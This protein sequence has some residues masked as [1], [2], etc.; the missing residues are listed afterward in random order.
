MSP[1]PILPRQQDQAQA[2]LPSALGIGS[3][4][5]APSVSSVYIISTSVASFS[6]HHHFASASTSG[7]PSPTAP[8]IEQLYS[9]AI[10]QTQPLTAFPSN[11]LSP[12]LQSDVSHSDTIPWGWICGASVLFLVSTIMLISWF[13]FWS[14][15]MKELREAGGMDGPQARAIRRY[16][17]N[18][19]SDTSS[20]GYSDDDRNVREGATYAYADEYP[21]PY[22]VLSGQPNRRLWSF[23]FRNFRSLSDAEAEIEEGKV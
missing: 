16:R 18:S 8:S 19:F 15:T 10:N 2:I 9:I 11:S 20:E 17:S 12:H 3:P 23:G 1:T 21:S 6:S 5:T 22:A 4:P 7:H 14:G 13:T